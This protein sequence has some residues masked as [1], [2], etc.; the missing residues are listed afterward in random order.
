[1][2]RLNDMTDQNVAAAVAVWSDPG[3]TAKEFGAEHEATTAA[4]R[5]RLTA[6]AAAGL[7]V[8]TGFVRFLTRDGALIWED[9]ADIRRVPGG[10]KVY[11]NTEGD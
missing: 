10:S 4:A 6:V 8:D 9:A 11:R 5:K 7:I 3:I 2:Q 1:M